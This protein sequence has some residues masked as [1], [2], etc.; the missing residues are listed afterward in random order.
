VGVGSCDV[1][2]GSERGLDGDLG[3]AFR[4]GN[5][6]RGEAEPSNERKEKLHRG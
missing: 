2:A 5:R 4:R 3:E 1:L 6:N